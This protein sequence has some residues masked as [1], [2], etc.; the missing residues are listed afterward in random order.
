M[1]R[2]LLLGGTLDARRLARQLAERPDLDATLSLA[3]VTSAPPD[4]GIPMRIGGFGGAGG[5]AHY[6]HE[7]SVDWLVDA[8]HPYAARISAN[9]AEAA[10]RASVNRLAL[11]RPPWQ[12][13]AGDDWQEF[14]DWPALAAAIP[15][16]ARVFLAAGQ[17]GIRALAPSPEGPGPD[18]TIIARALNRPV[19]TPSTVEFI[20]A[21]PARTWQ[22]EAALFEV[23][24]ISHVI[25]KNSGG[26][27][28]RAKLDA[29]RRLGLPVLM[30][31]RPAPPPGPLYPDAES[32]LAALTP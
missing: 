29:A 1:T 10:G 11:W 22:E 23:Q 24:R 25:A 27:A 4:P 5:L 21:L 20:R 14:A 12:P 3:G 7:Q 15:K 19:G 31:A 6:L 8:T 2:L 18:A 32:L 30:L 26:T 16:G 17:D 13:E 9:A 28:S